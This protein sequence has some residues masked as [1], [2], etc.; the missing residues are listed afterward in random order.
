MKQIRITPSERVELQQRFNVGK[1]YVLQ[2]LRFK[3]NGPTAEKIR[4]AALE[5]GGRYVDPDFSPNCRTQY[6]G[7]KIIQTFSEQVVL[8][9]NRNTGNITLLQ[10]GEVVEQLK[11]ESMATW[12]SMAMKAQQL[13][14]SVMVANKQSA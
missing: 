7:D 3:K 14:E 1:N 11:N 4:R 13:A 10:R 9:I 6:Q 12:N 8:E 5:L 2:V